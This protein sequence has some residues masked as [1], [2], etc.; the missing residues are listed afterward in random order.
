MKRNKAGIA[1]LGHESYKKPGG[2]KSPGI[3]GIAQE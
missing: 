3:V 1:I 2:A